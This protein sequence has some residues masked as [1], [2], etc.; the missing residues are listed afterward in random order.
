MLD[1]SLPTAAA[2]RIDALC[3][4]FESALQ[5][6]QSEGIE[7]YVQKADP[8]DRDLLR[9]ELQR[10][11][12]DFERDSALRRRQPAIDRSQQLISTD[13]VQTTPSN[14]DPS[15]EVARTQVYTPSS[16]SV[17]LDAAPAVLALDRYEVRE[18]LG[19]GGFG[20][21]YRAF[22]PEL[23]RE[24]AIKVPVRSPEAS[25]SRAEAYLA[26]ARMLAGLD[27]PGIVPVYDAGRTDGGQCFVV[28]KFVAGGDLAHWLTRERPAFG[29][30][31]EIV[32]QVADALGHAHQR[33]LVHRDIKPAN[34]L[35]DENGRPLVADFGMALAD[36]SF[37]RGAKLC[38]T[39][40]YMSPEQAEGKGDRVDA[41][42]DIY[43]LGIVFYEMLTGRRPY[44]YAEP[45]G[46]I[47]E[48]ISGEIRPPR[49]LN[50]SIPPELERICL[51]ALARQVGDRY[52]TAFDLAADL[53]RFLDG[54]CQETEKAA[55]YDETS[56]PSGKGRRMPGLALLA[57][58]FAALV[59]ALAAKVLLPERPAAHFDM[60]ELQVARVEGKR[61]LDEEQV[62]Y[63][64]VSD[65]QNVAALPE[66]KL[67][68]D[69]AFR[70]EG[71]F[72]S[73]CFWRLLWLDTS[74]RWSM[75]DAPDQTQA[76]FFYPLNRKMVTI[77]AED[78][79]GTHLLVMVAG[80]KPL[81][82]QVLTSLAVTP[83]PSFEQPVFWSNSAR[84]T[85]R[86]AGRE[87]Q[88]SDSYLASLAAQ[89]PHG[90]KLVAALFLPTE[91]VP[92]GPGE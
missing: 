14:T 37:G 85:S 22:D 42:S 7:G 89:L 23:R 91:P 15:G 90:Q 28:S 78:P 53:R 66:E 31:A 92:R 12:G 30:A 88:T 69:E 61:A 86:G 59:V 46:L 21:V 19:K 9:H 82:R 47:D 64:L 43:S 27:H 35:L 62:P 51:K 38:G 32:A 79:P 10:I 71:R 34:I 49:Q 40:A 5:A 44:R 83:P 77:A 72:A 39:P 80:E 87:L 41:R 8:V 63:S 45:T 36:D 18:V 65:G 33:G 3:L 25:V 55:P 76:D 75:G 29:K 74:G 20:V 67:D 16:D 54:D 24:V 68:A 13:P 17:E 58:L 1:E 2:A 6:G 70:L 84:E 73:P 48:I 57:A 52:T 11:R 4:E 81:G 56:S 26:E 50:P 60:L